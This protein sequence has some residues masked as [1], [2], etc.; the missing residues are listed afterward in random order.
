MTKLLAVLLVLAA[1]P[2]YAMGPYGKRASLVAWNAPGTS[3]LVRVSYDYAG[4][5]HIDFFIIGAT[6]PVQSFSLG[7][8]LVDEAGCAR[9]ARELNAALAKR[10]FRGVR[11]SCHAV[12]SEMDDQTAI[13]TRGDAAVSASWVTQPASRAPD[14]RE[15]TAA[16]AEEAAGLGG[17]V[18]VASSGKLVLVFGGLERDQVSGNEDPDSGPTGFVAYSIA[19]GRLEPIQLAD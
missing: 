12:S 11:V 1:A 17:H 8:D 18:S 13:A 10:R 3:A 7:G 14:A 4:G 9:G 19:S 6:G 15:R 2:A 5:N 16:R